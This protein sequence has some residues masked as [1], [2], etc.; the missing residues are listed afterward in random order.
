[1]VTITDV[2]KNYYSK[3]KVTCHA[4]SHISL[5][6]PEKGLVFLVGESGSGKTTLLNLIGTL[7]TPDEGKIAFNDIALNTLSGKD[8]DNFRNH[9]IGFVFQDFNLISNY[10]VGSNISLALELQGKVHNK[11][12]VCELLERVGLSS[13]AGDKPFYDRRISELS[14]GQKQRVAIARALI[15]DPD[16]ILA[17]EPTGSL[18]KENANSLFQLLKQLSS[19]RLVFVVSHDEDLAKKYADRI[20]R[21]DAG[22]I[23]SDDSLLAVPPA[24]STAAAENPAKESDKKRQS[25]LPLKRCLSISLS[26]LTHKKLR[27]VFSLLASFITLV[28]FGFSFAVS[29]SDAN[30][31]QVQK[32]YENGYQMAVVSPGGYYVTSSGSDAPN[33]R[34][35]CYTFSK[36]QIKQIQ[37]YSSGKEMPEVFGFDSTSS[38]KPNFTD[39]L[40]VSA[41]SLFALGAGNTNPYLTLALR[42]FNNLFE[43]D[44]DTGYA[45]A[46]LTADSRFK[47][48]SL[49][50]LPQTYSQ[51]G[52][53]DFQADLFIRFGYSSSDGKVTEVKSPDDLIGKAIG[54]YTISGVFS[55][56]ESKDLYSQYD[57]QDYSMTN[58]IDMQYQINGVHPCTFGFVKKGFSQH[59]IN[60]ARNYPDGAEIAYENYL[61]HVLLK[62]SGNKLADE[63]FFKKM[64]YSVKGGP[65]EESFH[66]AASLLSVYSG[67]TDASASLRD[68]DFIL[69][70]SIV[71][72][73]FGFLSILLLTLF[74]TGSLEDR[75]KEFTIL[76]S[77]GCPKKTVALIAFIES[78][79]LALVDFILS[80]AGILI[81][82]N[83]LNLQYRFPVF[84]FTA[85]DYLVL[86]FLCLLTSLLSTIFPVVRL[87]N[88]KLISQLKE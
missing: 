75:Q 41:E 20:I 50:Q 8:L 68:Y 70:I 39:S 80:S 77:L 31:P 55:T 73:V 10:S 35:D 64:K 45:D 78:L 65:G 51:I 81:L 67:Y 2:S 66:Y 23:V 40:A 33:T 79:A 47:D 63:S 85:V 83:C 46:K 42:S 1:M 28:C 24:D 16:L 38:P 9:R 27:L 6:L 11:N 82:F 29:H 30:L 61:H 59:L 53:T 60:A 26:C 58:D 18:D 74:L 13:K 72:L 49:C 69:T 22:V 86:F 3:N 43:I 36:D 71:S 32:L 5:T 44:S 37:D 84:Q 52:I 54:N 14:T 57:R 19:S 25:N 76:R 48:S 34:H 56:E 17:D 15:K 87:S 4:L 62:L 12:K 21:I 7:D 88:K